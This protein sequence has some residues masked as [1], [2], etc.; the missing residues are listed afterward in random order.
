MI[1]QDKWISS[2]PNINTESRKIANQ[3]DHD[4]WMKT[5]P[6]KEKEKYK[7]VKKYSLVPILFVCGLLLVST[8]TFLIL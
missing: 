5:I 1:N 2:L 4:R 7:Y 3:L 8:V 6:K